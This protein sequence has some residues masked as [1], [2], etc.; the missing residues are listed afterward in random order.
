[1][2]PG[3]SVLSEHFPNFPGTALPIPVVTQ[4]AATLYNVF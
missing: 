4:G 3:V 2:Y 1:M